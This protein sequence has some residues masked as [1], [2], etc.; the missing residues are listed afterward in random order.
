V[1]PGAV[2]VL[3]SGE[4]GV[5]EEGAVRGVGAAEVVGELGAVHAPPITAGQRAVVVDRR[6]HVR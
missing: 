1:A 4:H 6:H 5:S 3:G 2:V